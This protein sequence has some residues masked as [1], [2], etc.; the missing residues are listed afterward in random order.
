M[1]LNKKFGLRKGQSEIMGLAMVMILLAVGLLLFISFGLRNSDSSLSN[2]FTYKQLPVLLNKAIFETNT[3]ESDCYGEKIQKLLIKAGEGN[4][5][6]CNNGVSSKEFAKDFI[7]D[8][9]NQTLG[10]WFMEYRYTVYRGNDFSVCD[11]VPNGGLDSMADSSKCVLKIH[12]TDDYCFMK[13]INTENFFFR[14]NT[15]QLLNIK[16]DICG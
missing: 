8:A 11:P 1:V 7:T 6:T 2:E 15:G 4:T 13:D 14:M 12:N 16:L 9:L 10:A 3:L 5:L